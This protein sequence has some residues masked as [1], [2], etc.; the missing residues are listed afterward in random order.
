MIANPSPSSLP[1]TS[2]TVGM[3]RQDY[4]GR[5]AEFER[6]FEA[7]SQAVL[8][9][10]REID[11]EVVLRKLV[12]TVRELLGAR[13]AALGIPD[14]QGGFDRFLTSGMSDELIEQIGP[15]P[16]TH[17]LLGAMLEDTASYRTDDIRDDPR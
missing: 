3:C 2:S 9:V 12:D 15:L 16:R 1:A 8:D 13:Y 6:A 4:A 10:A 17:G 5:V 11:L 7:L 14:G